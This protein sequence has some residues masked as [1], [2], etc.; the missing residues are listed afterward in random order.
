MRVPVAFAL[1]EQLREVE[2]VVGERSID[3]VDEPQLAVAAHQQ[4]LEGEVA[5]HGR[6]LPAE[7]GQR[8]PGQGGVQ[9]LQQVHEGAAGALVD[10]A[11]LGQQ[12]FAR[13]RRA[14]VRLGGLGSQVRDQRLDLPGQGFH[15]RELRRAQKG[16]GVPA[17]NEGHVE[18]EA[19]LHHALVQHL[20]GRGRPR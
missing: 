15:G 6:R 13:R 11:R 10:L 16:D 7:H 19:A 3:G 20:R 14:P 17:R 12:R 1:L 8:K 2:P 4:V 9:G 5:V 18:V